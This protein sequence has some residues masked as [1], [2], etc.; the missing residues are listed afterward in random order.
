MTEI[1]ASWRLRE[2]L[3]DRLEE[4]TGEPRHVTDVEVEFI[5]EQDDAQNWSAHVTCKP[6]Y[7]A[8]LNNVMDQLEAEF[9]VIDFA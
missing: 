7:V 8:A 6:E 5:P 3:E 2:I 4:I 1:L 9:P